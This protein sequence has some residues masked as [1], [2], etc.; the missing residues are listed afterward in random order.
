MAGE[1]L[2][3][4]HTERG[5]LAELPQREQVLLAAGRVH[6]DLWVRE[7]EATGAAVSMVCQRLS[8]L[9]SFYRYAAAHDLVA[10]A[11]T[12]WVAR[13]SVDRDHTA[14]IGLDREQ[15]RALLAA[16]MPTPAR[17]SCALRRSWGCWCATRSVPTSSPPLTSTR[18]R[19]TAATE[20]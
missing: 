6:V 4:A 13:P 19:R 11:P 16:A 9:S 15:A 1:L 2:K 14:T 17:N 7:Q 18:S 8:A 20:C 5:E 3:R 10:V 12:A